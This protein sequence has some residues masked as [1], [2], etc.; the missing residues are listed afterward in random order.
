MCRAKGLRI[1][2]IPNWFNRNGHHTFLKLYSDQV[3]KIGS[4]MR[5]GKNQGSAFRQQGSVE[6]G[7]S[8]KGKWVSQATLLH[9]SLA[10]FLRLL[11]TQGCGGKWREKWRAIPQPH[12]CPS[13]CPDPKSPTAWLLLDPL[14]SLWDRLGTGTLCCS[15]CTWT[16]VSSSNKIQRNYKGLKITVCMCSWGK[17]WTSYKE[18]KKPNCHFWRARKKSRVLRMPPAHNTTKGVGKT[19][20]PPLWPDPWTHPYPHPISGTSSPAPL[21]EQASKETCYLFLLPPCCSRDS[22]KALPEFVVWPLIS[23]YWL[24]RPRT[25]VSNTLTF[26]LIFPFSFRCRGRTLNKSYSSTDNTLSL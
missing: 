19:P 13:S 7:S 8:D 26:F 24:R 23:F 6:I 11:L 3:T 2:E 10:F 25:L 20:K 17:F 22:N 9:S 1:Q 16:N 14:P 12:R 4:T 18:T 21:R 15:A 5:I